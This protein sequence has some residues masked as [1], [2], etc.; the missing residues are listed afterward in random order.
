MEP[1]NSET[2]ESDSDEMQQRGHNCSVTNGFKFFS[3]QN[4][5]FFLSHNFY[6]LEKRKYESKPDHQP[7][8]CVHYERNDKTYFE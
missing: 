7:Y 8:R 6:K 5:I 2:A 3:S 4:S 1:S